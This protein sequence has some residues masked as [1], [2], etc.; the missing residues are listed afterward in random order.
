LK[1]IKRTDQS[2]LVVFAGVNLTL[3]GQ[4]VTGNG[5][6]YTAPVNWV[7]VL[8]EAILPEGYVSGGWT[9]TN[10]VWAINATGSAAFLP[11][12][13]KAKIESLTAASLEAEYEDISYDSLMW[14][15]DDSARYLLTQALAVGSVPVGMYWR[16]VEGVPHDVTYSY[17]QGLALKMAE[18]ALAI[19]EQLTSK[20]ALVEAATTAAAIRAIVW[21]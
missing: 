13:R 14:A 15:S 17:L 21:E 2:N 9:Y 19:D 1:I 12:L 4:V 16:D 7:M 3:V 20:M 10:G 18:R 8:E 5:W 11:G 6:T